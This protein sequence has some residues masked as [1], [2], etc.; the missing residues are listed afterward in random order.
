VW[1]SRVEEG[2]VPCEP[3][4]DVGDGLVWVQ[5]DLF[6][7]DGAPQ[8]LDEHVV[9]PA[10]LAVHADLDMLRAQHIEERRAGKLRALI[11]VEYLRRAEAIERVLEPGDRPS[12]PAKKSISSACSPIFACKA[13]TSTGPARRVPRPRAR[14]PLPLVQP[15][16]SSTA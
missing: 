16:G 10:A 3:G 11:G 4:P 14:K 1:P 7:F 9:A 6:V 12:A 15:A 2:E 5:I 13:F 8:A